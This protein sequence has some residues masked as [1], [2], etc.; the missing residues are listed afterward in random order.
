M[1]SPPNEPSCTHVAMFS[2]GINSWAAAT[3]LAARYGTQRLTLLFAD[4]RIED[5][6]LYRFLVEAACNIF[7]S[8]V[9]ADVLLTISQ[10]PPLY[11]PERS[12]ALACLQEEAMGKIP[13][14]RWIADGRTPWEVFFDE[15]FLGNTH[16]DPC[17]KILK[18]QLLDTWL[19]EHCDVADT[20]LM[21]GFTWSEGHR[22]ARM[23][24][25]HDGW[26]RWAP[27]LE[28]PY[29]TKADMLTM[30]EHEGLRPPRLYALGMQHCNCG[31][32][33][34]KAGQAAWALLLR[35]FPERYQAWEEQEARFRTFIGADVAILRDR[36][37][38]QLRTLTL[39]DFRERLE[40]TGQYDLLDWGT[41][42]CFQHQEESSHAS[43]PTPEGG[44]T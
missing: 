19:K 39:R 11:T 1:S 9:P 17:S 40:G 3:R 29:L 27:L 22:M 23:L 26:Q 7:G 2:G 35:T 30:A 44:S 24:A 14:L 31:G 32:A 6:D 28:P 16:I 25:Y 41:C 5:D 36:T 20:L 43:S 42:G 21:Y 18:R 8:P 12:L 37:R 33:C 4:T 15:R 10:L 38:G 13:S 34:V